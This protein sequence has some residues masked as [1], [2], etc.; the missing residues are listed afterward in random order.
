MK[1]RDWTQCSMGRNVGRV[2]RMQRS[3]RGRWAFYLLAAV[4]GLA[5]LWASTRAAEPLAHG[6]VRGAGAVQPSVLHAMPA[7]GPPMAAG[8]H[9]AFRHRHRQWP[10]SLGPL[11]RRLQVTLKQIQQTLLLVRMGVVEPSELQRLR[12]VAGKLRQQIEQRRARYRTQSRPARVKHGR[13]NR[14]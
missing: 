13:L 1:G 9:P 5:V 2:I 8:G 11:S 10:A 12:Q 4:L 3:S 6:P 7:V 14:C